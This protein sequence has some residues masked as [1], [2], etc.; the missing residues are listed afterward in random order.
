MKI[1]AGKYYQLRNGD[2]VGPIFIDEE[3]PF[4]IRDSGYVWAKGGTYH[5]RGFPHERDIV[6]KAKNPNK[7][8]KN[9]QRLY[10][11]A[12]DVNPNT[13]V[14]TFDIVAGKVDCSSIKME[15]IQ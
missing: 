13:H 7:P 4:P 1:K 11:G 8:T 2:V 12:K 9:E 10:W 15:V 14:I 3:E 6:A 5:Y